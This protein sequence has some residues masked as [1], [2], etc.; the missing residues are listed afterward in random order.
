MHYTN[1]IDAAKRRA[2]MLELHVVAFAGPGTLKSIALVSE[3][4]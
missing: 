2:L 4:Q 1:L 3:H